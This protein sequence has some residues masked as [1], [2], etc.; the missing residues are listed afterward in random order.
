MSLIA[1]YPL[2][3]DLSDYSG[4]GY[5]LG[6]LNYKWRNTATWFATYGHPTTMALMDNYFNDTTLGNPTSG[7]GIFKEKIISF[8]NSQVSSSCINK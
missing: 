7:S 3:T 8:G 1:W 6:C 4:N 5:D 2:D